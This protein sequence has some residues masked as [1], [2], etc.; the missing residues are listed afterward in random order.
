M[1]N[2]IAAAQANGTLTEMEAKVMDFLMTD[3][4]FAEYSFSDLTVGDVARRAEIDIKSI[5][6]VVGS[7]VKKGYLWV[8]ERDGEVPPLVYAN[9]KGYQLSDEYETRWLPQVP[10]YELE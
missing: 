2:K 4:Y 6:G 7:L 8:S 1:M 3:G 10:S 9:L 5:K